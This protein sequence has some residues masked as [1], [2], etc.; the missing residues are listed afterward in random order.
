MGTICSSKNSVKV[1][2]AEVKV[3]LVAGKE[4]VNKDFDLIRKKKSQIFSTDISESSFVELSTPR[5]GRL[6]RWRRGELIGEGAY[7][8]VYQC[9]N[10]SNGELLAVK[11]FTVITI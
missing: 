6:T 3:E 5:N 1:E 7:A 8:K 10:L 2:Q 11:H 4:T 9:I